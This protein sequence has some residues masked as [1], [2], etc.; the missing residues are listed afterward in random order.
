MRFARE[1]QCRLAEKFIFWKMVSKVTPGGKADSDT[2]NQTGAAPAV[3]SGAPPQGAAHAA[4]APKRNANEMRLM[5]KMLDLLSRNKVK[6]AMDF[7]AQHLKAIEQSVADGGWTRAR[8]LE[9]FEEDAP[10][11]VGRGEKY[12]MRSEVRAEQAL[13]LR[14]G[15]GPKGAPKGARSDEAG[16]AVNGATESRGKGEAF[17]GKGFSFGAAS[18]SKAKGKDKAG[19]WW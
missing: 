7:A 18:K 14:S 16:A 17:S 1:S 5:C 2:D 4:A 10:S 6:R 19:K 15:S 11:L 9:V 3:A 8:F 13:A 12:M